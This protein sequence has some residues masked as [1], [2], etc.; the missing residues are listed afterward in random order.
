MRRV[1]SWVYTIKQTFGRII[2]LAVC[3]SDLSFTRQGDHKIKFWICGYLSFGNFVFLDNFEF[4][5]FAGKFQVRTLR[6]LSDLTLFPPVIIIFVTNSVAS[7]LHLIYNPNLIHRFIYL[8]GE[9]IYNYCG[10]LLQL[11]HLKS[12]PSSQVLNR[13]V[14]KT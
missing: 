11:N 7:C 5:I 1:W 10:A 9:N 12:Y 13:K 8:F 3:D 4:A 14:N 2:S 6:K